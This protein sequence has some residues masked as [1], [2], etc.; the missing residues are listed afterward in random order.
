[1]DELLKGLGEA[2]SEEEK[3]IALTAFLASSS[4][5]N[6]FAEQ[7]GENAKVEAQEKVFEL[8]KDESLSDGVRIQAA[9]VLKVI[10]R[11]KV[12]IQKVVTFE[13]VITMLQMASLFPPDYKSDP[14]LSEA[15][16]K[17]LANQSAFKYPT[18]VDEYNDEDDERELKEKDAVEA[19]TEAAQLP[20]LD[21]EVLAFGPPV[22]GKE[23][24]P[25]QAEVAKCLVN[26]IT[27]DRRG[28][29]MIEALGVLPRLL[30]RLGDKNHPSQLRFPM[31]R[32]LLRM[33]FERVAKLRLHESKVL[34][35]L[36]DVLE[37]CTGDLENTDH[38]VDLVECLKVN[39]LLH[40][41]ST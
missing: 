22:P 35:T 3:A 20:K 36:A 12:A 21:D 33:S 25:L 31:L 5:L 41:S 17:K 14:A 7:Y 4:G 1:M 28:E 16:E 8:V 40:I 29:T 13:N 30:W 2:S 26:I 38:F 10:L 32:M 11:D 37:I 27:R 9:E 15:L 39:T 6:S 23:S 18:V 24:A 34:N 19:A